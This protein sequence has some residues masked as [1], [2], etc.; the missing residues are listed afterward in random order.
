MPPKQQ[1]EDH[2]R[3]GYGGRPAL[4]RPLVELDDRQEEDEEAEVPRDDS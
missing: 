3:K 1:Q 4:G 2:R